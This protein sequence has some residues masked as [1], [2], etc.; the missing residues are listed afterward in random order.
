MIRNTL[1]I[2]AS[3]LALAMLAACGD[4]PQ[5]AADAKPKKA[6]AQAWEGAQAAYT[7]PGWKAGDKTSW[8]TQLKTRAQQGQNEYNRSPATSA[9][10]KPAQ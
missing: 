10:A 4:K 3:A 5:T 6:D 8:E 2:A 7:A 1:A 9:E